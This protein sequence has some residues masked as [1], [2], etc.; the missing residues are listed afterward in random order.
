MGIII[1]VTRGNG[2]S[3]FL[4][5]WNIR[6][7]LVTVSVI[8]GALNGIIDTS[9]TKAITEKGRICWDRTAWIF[10]FELCAV[11]SIKPAILVIQDAIASIVTNIERIFVRV[12]EVA[13]WILQRYEFSR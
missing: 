7:L 8:S 10:N 6:A 4:T 5:F 11:I 9:I 12:I 13:V 2:C 1:E 3:N